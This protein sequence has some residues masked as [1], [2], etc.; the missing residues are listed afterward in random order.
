MAGLASNKVRKEGR[1]T[2][3]EINYIHHG[4]TKQNTDADLIPWKM[5]NFALLV[6]M[7]FVPFS[8]IC[9]NWYLNSWMR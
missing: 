4:K 7:R 5:R 1:R 9:S 2:K 8:M 3:F 6:S